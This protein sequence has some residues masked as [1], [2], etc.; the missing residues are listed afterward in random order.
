MIPRIIGIPFLFLFAT[1]PQLSA[2]YITNGDFESGYAGWT[3]LAVNNKTDLW[4]GNN[5]NPGAGMGYIYSTINQS[6]DPGPS[7]S[8]ILTQDNIAIP[9][10][11]TSLILW[12]SMSINT[13]EAV[14]AQ[15]DILTVRIKDGNGV[16]LLSKDYSDD[17]SFAVHVNSGGSIT[18]ATASVT[19]APQWIN[20]P[21]SLSGQNME[22]EL[23]IQTDADNPSIFRVDDMYINVQGCIAPL[24]TDVQ[25]SCMYNGAMAKIDWTSNP[26]AQS[27]QLQYRKVGNS[28]TTASGT[29]S[30]NTYTLLNLDTNSSYEF[31]VQADCGSQT[32]Q[33]SSTFTATTPACI[34]PS[35]VPVPTNLQ[36]TVS[37]N[38]LVL[39]E[40]DDLG[41]NYI[42]EVQYRTP[43]N[44]W[45]L[46]NSS[47]SITVLFGNLG[48]CHQYEWRVRA[49]C[50]T[51][52]SA[53]SSLA[54][55]ATSS[56]CPPGCN[57]AQLAPAVVDAACSEV[58]FSWTQVPVNIAS[59]FEVE[60]CE[61]GGACT[62]GAPITTNSQTWN[63]LIPG[64]DYQWR[65]KTNCLNG[66]QG[67]SLWGNFTLCVPPPPIS[68]YPYI[69]LTKGSY[70]SGENLVIHGYS[71]STN[72]T[73]SSLI[74][75]PD[76]T[77]YSLS[78]VTNNMGEFA[79]SFPF[80]VD[81]L[82]GNYEV[83]SIDNLTS[84][85][86]SPK[87]FR[88]QGPTT[89]FASTL[90]IGSPTAQDEIVVNT[91]FQI[92]W[93]ELMVPA[94]Q[95]AEMNAQRA[96][97]YEIAYSSDGGNAWLAHSTV[98]GYHTINETAFLSENISFSTPGSTYQLRIRDG[99]NPSN[100]VISETFSVVAPIS[101]QAL[102]QTEWDFSY[103]GEFRNVEL[104]GLAADG[105]ARMYL[106]VESMTG[107]MIQQVQV[108]LMDADGNL[109]P[110]ILG[111]VSP[112]TIID[113][114][115]NEANG[116]TTTSATS[117]TL[118]DGKFWF[119]YVA[120]DDF[121]GT[122]YDE[123]R[124]V[125]AQFDISFQGGGTLQLEKDITIV[126]PPLVLTHGLGGKPENWEFF[127]YDE[128]QN[129]TQR[130]LSDSR[131]KLVRDIRLKN[132]IGSLQENAANLVK[133]K[134]T[135]DHSFAGILGDMRRKGYAANQVDYVGH[136]MGGIVLREI[137]TNFEEEFTR[138][139]SWENV[140]FQNY[141]Q[142]YTNKMITIGSP[143][144]GSPIADF[145]VRYDQIVGT[146]LGIWIN[147]RHKKDPND[148]LFRFFRRKNPGKF[149]PIYVLGEGVENLQTTA[150]DFVQI[151]HS[152][153]LISTDYF[154]TWQGNSSNLP[155]NK[156][157]DLRGLEGYLSFVGNW[158]LDVA[159]FFE[160][161]P[162]VSAALKQLS[163]TE[164]DPVIKGLRTI[165]ILSGVGSFLH[166]SD[167]IVGVESQ[168][169]GIDQSSSTHVSSFQDLNHFVGP[170]RQQN[171][172]E[173][174]SQV[175]YLLDIPVTSPEFGAIPATGNK[176]DL[177]ID[178]RLGHIEPWTDVKTIIDTSRLK[179][180]SPI[181][182][183]TTE[184]DT[185]L[186]VQMSIPDTTDLLNLELFFQNTTYRLEVNDTLV[187]FNL[188]VN[189]NFL[190]HQS[191]Y[192][193]AIFDYSDSVEVII[194]TVGIDIQ[195]TSDFLSLTVS[196][197]VMYLD[198]GQ[199]KYPYYTGVFEDFITESANFSDKITAQVEDTSIVT[200]LPETKGFIGKNAGETKATITYGNKEDDIYLIVSPEVDTSS[201]V[202]LE[203]VIF[204]KVG[205][206]GFVFFNYPN[207]A[208]ETTILYY[209]L[210]QSATVSIDLFD[211]QGKKIRNLMKPT[212]Q[213]PATYEL[214]IDVSHLSNG[215]Y[216]YQLRI[217]GRVY[218]G[219]MVIVK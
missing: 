80:P 60:V 36:S 11:A 99:L 187:E 69:E 129:M 125:T 126:R 68:V 102:I 191:L 124:T 177:S 19:Y 188:Q 217:D 92:N 43:G 128:G 52:V 215:L 84:N 63:T 44:N 137:F 209:E 34:C 23:E 186:M 85:H 14:G 138:T 165:Q 154:P 58:N 114:Y 118:K 159:A 146:A 2:Q 27:Y 174:G 211:L 26:I 110:E 108:S 184:T 169:A 206:S 35:S 155:P 4:I 218:S 71:F 16:S 25:T 212:D 28:W 113:T 150:V 107:N 49:R 144:E 166:D 181:A 6:G 183:F 161:N 95:Y 140:P 156:V 72:Q 81:F 192:A 64:T 182:N 32:S 93:S 172:V 7:L 29:I 77:Q 139:G 207:P 17:E 164:R 50:N 3:Q 160:Q 12:F 48:N 9:A 66:L 62:T 78:S 13:F 131:F 200:F 216:M 203:D 55:F 86:S 15:D 61:L 152:A 115:S 98:S 163:K 96:Y 65:V 30:N 22:I 170:S 173:I 116:K 47:S 185:I 59:S 123:E 106:T 199:V 20:L 143:H 101:N 158:L 105:T 45:T 190:D 132:P 73:I 201:I 18:G 83:R 21:L 88:F 74:L 46:H 204:P 67:T 24:I 31:Q 56:G 133:G 180:E 33:Y 179:I 219:K 10:N 38:D 39:L 8:G 54:T 75:A 53:W 76:G 151:P 97:T 189:N 79:A 153:H 167:L 136:S 202:G 205:E 147:Q 149:P 127:R 91:P 57:P 90:A 103:P 157:Q 51:G 208:K 176:T 197:T 82:P 130:F 194:D 89:G 142:G 168:L 175:K 94:M 5:T 213:S 135:N 112:A 178:D 104:K 1:T 119:W 134:V 111:K 87:F 198:E 196:P 117:S 210:P 40:W 41:G 122:Q 100:E 171:S 120:P 148:F 195:T 109:A 37:V 121:L 193:K 145:V 42:Y 162:Q 214:P 70:Q 141:E